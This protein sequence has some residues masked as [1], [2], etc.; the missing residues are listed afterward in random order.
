[1]DAATAE[2]LLVIHETAEAVWRA[3]TDVRTGAGVME[4]AKRKKAEME[5]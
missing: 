3:K 2:Q 5:G 4:R 1:M